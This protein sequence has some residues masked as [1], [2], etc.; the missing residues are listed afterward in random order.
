MSKEDTE[1]HIHKYV[2]KKEDKRQFVIYCI[3]NA[4][5]SIAVIV[6]IAC[7]KKDDNA[8]IRFGPHENLIVVGIHCNTWAR[9]GGFVAVICTYRIAETAV[10]ELGFNIINFVVYDKSVNLVV[11]MSKNYLHLL[12][13]IQYLF[14]NTRTVIM[15]VIA[16]TQVDI[17]LIGVLASEFASIFCIRWLLNRKKFKVDQDTDDSPANDTRKP[18]NEMSS[19]LPNFSLANINHRNQLLI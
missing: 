16:V 11:G 14:F 1:V 18:V 6:L 2:I 19:L 3:I 9:W 4:L 7:F 17:A 10:N 13:N 12:T 5:I 8:Y 15:T